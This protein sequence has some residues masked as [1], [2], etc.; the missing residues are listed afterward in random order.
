MEKAFDTCGDDPQQN[1]QTRA[2]ITSIQTATGRNESKKADPSKI[3]HRK[4]LFVSFS[5][6]HL[7]KT[8][9]LVNANHRKAVARP[10]PKTQPS[11]NDQLTLVQSIDSSPSKTT[12]KT[13]RLDAYEA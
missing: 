1:D 11:H 4:T 7:A 3:E 13:S 12:G 8:S 6:H 10:S 5:V 9:F 2:T